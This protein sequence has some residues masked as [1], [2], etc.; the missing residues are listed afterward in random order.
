[1]QRRSSGPCLVMP[2]LVWP[3]LVLADGASID[4]VYH[5]YVEQ[6][7]WELEW[8]ATFA[9]EDPASGDD[10]P[11]VHRLGLGR[12][13]SEF[14]FV[15]GY[16]IGEKTASEG[17]DL[18]AYE[19]EVLW[20]LSEQG[21]YAV[22]YAV[23]FEL[24]KA[25][26]RDIWETAAVLLLEKEFGRVSTT[27]NVG[28]IFESGAD[29]DDELETALALQARYRYSPRLEPAMEMYLAEDTFGLGPVLAGSERLAPT[30]ALKWEAGI[31]FG[32]DDTTADYT[33]RAVLEYEF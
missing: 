32:L 33:F 4:K 16:L 3:V 20:Q 30:K 9:N 15:E 13:V 24:E 17:F 25:H 10:D 12:A 5:P 22:D 18:E 29:I 6:L 11:Q 1:M 14:V 19:V 8:R 7:E 26:Q 31:I 23:L 2:F 21:E 28:L 27:A